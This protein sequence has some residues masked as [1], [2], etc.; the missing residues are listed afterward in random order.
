MSE[1]PRS[2][3]YP[4]N[5]R[6]KEF[7]R[8]L[9]SL[10]RPYP[11]P[12]IEWQ[13]KLYSQLSRI[14]R[15]LER[16]TTANLLSNEQLKP[17]RV[18]RG[19][20]LNVD[21]TKP[22]DLEARF[23]VPARRSGLKSRI[24]LFKK[25]NRTWAEPDTNEQYWKIFDEHLQPTIVSVSTYYHAVMSIVEKSYPRPGSNPYWFPAKWV[26]SYSKNPS[27]LFLT[28]LENSF[29][30]F[31]PTRIRQWTD[32]FWLHDFYH[33]RS[34][35]ISGPDPAVPHSVMSLMD[36]STAVPDDQILK[37]ELLM[38]ILC[39]RHILTL[40]HWPGHH[41]FPVRIMAPS[42][43][44]M[45]LTVGQYHQLLILS[46]HDG[47]G[48]IIQMHCEHDQ[49]HIRVSRHLNLK[50]KKC[51][52]IPKDGLIMAQWLLSK[53]IGSTSFS[54]LPRKESY[55]EDSRQQHSRQDPG[56]TWP[57]EIPKEEYGAAVAHDQ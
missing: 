18:V 42:S 19:A 38:G 6:E 23:F 51:T 8:T 1:S 45:Q 30:K 35:S 21:E 12:A 44:I 15:K 7:C 32:Q 16:P 20:D 37:S 53:P 28:L 34:L 9:Y 41:T 3:R 39:M 56:T 24:E 11:D 2:R 14:K 4:M 57:L 48:R 29:K 52:T 43:H 13:L 46:F 54:S 22:I 26:I 17:L 55:E 10:P 50:S 36:T 31:N 47:C 25:E 40:R 33:Y 27:H 49:L 5:T